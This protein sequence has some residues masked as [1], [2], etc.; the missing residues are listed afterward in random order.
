MQPIYSHVA[1]LTVTMAFFV[2]RTF[3][4]G[5]QRRERVLRQRVAYLLWVAAEHVEPCGQLAATE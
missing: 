2:W 3:T 5:R 4:E 1:L